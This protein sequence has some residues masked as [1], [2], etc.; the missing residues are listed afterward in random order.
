MMT[1]CKGGREVPLDGVRER[2]KGKRF[3]WEKVGRGQKAKG[4]KKGKDVI[5]LNSASRLH[6]TAPHH[7]QTPY[8][9]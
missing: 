2:E 1:I 4:K 3:I 7:T 8:K 5:P 9:N 6:L